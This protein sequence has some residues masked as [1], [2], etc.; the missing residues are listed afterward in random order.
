M[1]KSIFKRTF[2]EFETTIRYRKV[3][4]QTPKGYNV[5]ILK[6]KIIH[7]NFYCKELKFNHFKY[8]H[9]TCIYLNRD[10]SN[11]KNHEEIYFEFESELKEVIK[12]IR[13]NEIIKDIDGEWKINY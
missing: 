12:A 10:I 6:V 4:G 3:Y 7:S 13:K 2:N 11:V 9:H 8:L 5:Y 1:K